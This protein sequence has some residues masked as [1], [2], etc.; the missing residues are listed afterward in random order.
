MIEYYKSKNG[1]SVIPVDRNDIDYEYYKDIVLGI[2]KTLG[3]DHKKDRAQTTL[4][5]GDKNVRLRKNKRQH[6]YFK[7]EI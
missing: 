4:F 2:F 5:W 1:F 6:N 3:L 7:H